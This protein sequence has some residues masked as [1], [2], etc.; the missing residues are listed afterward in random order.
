M[1]LNITLPAA[2]LHIHLGDKTVYIFSQKSDDRLNLS[3]CIFSPYAVS[4]P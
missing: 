4:E 3:Q 2:V 1:Y